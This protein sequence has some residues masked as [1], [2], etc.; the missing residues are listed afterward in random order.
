[1]KITGR[2]ELGG[3]GH[4]GRAQPDTQAPRQHRKLL[5]ATGAEASSASESGERGKRGK[6]GNVL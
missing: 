3:R 5:P 2:A 6:R 4:R 1:M